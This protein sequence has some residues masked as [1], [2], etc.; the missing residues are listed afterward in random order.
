MTSRVRCTQ[1]P[2][3]PVPQDSR[4]CSTRWMG[5][6]RW[7]AKPWGLGS[8]ALYPWQGPG[9]DPRNSDGNPDSLQAAVFSTSIIDVIVDS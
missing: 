4:T 6:M 1:P 2:A 5:A 8:W 9:L 3:R 7:R